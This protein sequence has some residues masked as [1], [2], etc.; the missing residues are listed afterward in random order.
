MQ[1]TRK[2]FIAHKSLYINSWGEE[3]FHLVV[4]SKLE[5][6]CRWDH[7]LLLPDPTSRYQIYDVSLILHVSLYSKLTNKLIQ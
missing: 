2:K 5:L 7:T 3:P 1:Q 6:R 4:Y